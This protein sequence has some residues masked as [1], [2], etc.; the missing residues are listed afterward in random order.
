MDQR[1]AGPLASRVRYAGLR[2]PLTPTARQPESCIT[3]SKFKRGSGKDL[4]FN[5]KSFRLALAAKKE[6]FDLLAAYS[7]R[8]RGNYYSGKGGAKKYETDAWFAELTDSLSST[9][10]SGQIPIS[11]VAN[12]FQ[13]GKEVA[14][15]SSELESTLLKGV[16]RL[17]HDQTLKLNYMHMNHTFGESVSYLVNYFVRNGRE[18]QQGQWPYSNTK[19]D[20][21]SLGYELK[22]EG[23]KWVNLDA[24]VWM[25]KSNTRRHQNGLGVY[26]LTANGVNGK[27]S[28]NA[29]DD[30]VR[31]HVR[32]APPEHCVGV[33]NQVPE[34]LPN[35]DGHY[36]II[37]AAL[38]ISKHDRWGVNV[39]NRFK[40]HPA[41]SL[42]AG[43]DF[44]RERLNQWDASGQNLVGGHEYSYGGN[45]LGPRSGRR[46]QYNL[47]FIFDWAA[48]SW[49]QISGGYRY[50]DYWAHDDLISRKRA[51]RE[52][53]WEAQRSL[54][55]NGVFV[56]YQEILSDAEAAALD[57]R[58]MAE[59][60]EM[61][62]MLQD[63]PE[64]LNEFL[65]W[66][67]TPEV[68][69]DY[70]KINGVRY[71]Q[72][73]DR[74]SID[75]RFP[76]VGTHKGFADANPFRNGTI[77]PDEQ[78]DTAQSPTGKANRYINLHPSKYGALPADMDPWQQP[79]KIRG[80][81]WAP[82]LA[83]SIFLTDSARVYAR[84]SE[85]VR[86]PNLHEAT[87]GAWGYGSQT[88]RAT[89]PE[90]AYNWEIGYVQNLRPWLPELEYADFRVN[91]FNNRIEDY[92]DRDYFFNIVQ[93]KE[94]K[95]AGMEL[96]S[97]FDTGK[98]HVNF[99]AT[100][101]LKQKLCDKDYASFLDA[102][103]NRVP[104]C[105][106]GG[107]PLTFARTALQPQYSI[108]LDAGARLLENRLR[109][110]GRMTYHSAAKNK[111][112]EKMN[113]VSYLAF[114][115]P[116]YWNPIL[117]FDAS[118][119]YA[120]DRNLSVDL[121]VNNLTNRYY[122]DPMARISMPAPGRTVTLGITAAF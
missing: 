82:Q 17:P 29:W 23:N 15:T 83:A 18:G 54:T 114:V 44:T 90:H 112:E 118:A 55:A 119:S 38:Q 21:F 56:G 101:R 61:Y 67:P 43:G 3:H 42:T 60:H 13:A 69:A 76:N 51:A 35:T 36:N 78:V 98:Y 64:D 45:Y 14:N 111:D 12:Y 116:F 88:T 58:V 8:S 22:P 27:V 52:P 95:L 84:Y 48:T 5:D 104:V 99:G 2:P 107:F 32:N 49:L 62:E 20:T 11:Y 77:D 33:P 30:Y 50:S 70:D 79:G 66:A 72:P 74:E 115:R 68:Y 46:E 102:V 85:F 39:S 65:S 63:H 40:L 97:R 25:T 16:L 41:F 24:N 57:Q 37:P 26:G 4:N 28:D 75:I 53:G 93:F 6:N 10:G 71:S 34:K 91:Y 86:F 31:C 100:Y 7:Y 121:T 96:Q 81:G 73:N 94:K 108:N 87:Q 9:E 106:D 113:G 110:S 120:I 122:V 89:G 59:W 109:I 19:Q 47:Q 92:I 80:H 117:V 103:Y 105:V 1:T